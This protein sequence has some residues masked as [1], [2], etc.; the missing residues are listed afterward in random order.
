MLVK[1]V[2]VGIMVVGGIGFHVLAGE[3]ADPDLDDAGRQRWLGYLRLAAE[4]MTGLGALILLLTAAA[5]VG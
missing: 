1:H 3:V 4:A 5:Q 2:L